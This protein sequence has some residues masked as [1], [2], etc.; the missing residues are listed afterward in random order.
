MEL[1]SSE[2]HKY[3]KVLQLH[4]PFRACTADVGAADNKWVQYLACLRSADG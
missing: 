1:G 3:L 4:Q 2:A